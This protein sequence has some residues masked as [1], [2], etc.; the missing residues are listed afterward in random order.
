VDYQLTAKASGFVVGEEP[1]TLL[2]RQAITQA[3]L[4]RRVDAWWSR[5]SW[6]LLTV[7]SGVGASPQMNGHTP[8]QS[9]PAKAH[10]VVSQVIE[11]IPN[12]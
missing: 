1:I 7:L 2:G 9:L 8:V 4:G 3:A 12:P 6:E 10:T 5:G 11:D